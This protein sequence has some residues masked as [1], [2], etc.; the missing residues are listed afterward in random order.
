M[1]WRERDLPVSPWSRE[2]STKVGVDSAL[3]NKMRTIL[4]PKNS[5]QVQVCPLQTRQDVH[6]QSLVRVAQSSP[7]TIATPGWLSWPDW[8]GYGEG[9]APRK[10]TPK[11]SR[12]SEGG[13]SLRALQQET[14]EISSVHSA[15]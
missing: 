4:R 11:C 9:Q 8:L 1:Q 3:R 12:P 10:R 7:A 15:A 2:I 6:G 14:L 5:F 13:C